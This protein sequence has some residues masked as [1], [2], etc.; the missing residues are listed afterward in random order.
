MHNV[1]NINNLEVS[2]DY[3][4]FTVTS[5]ISPYDVLV[6]LGFNQSDF[7]VCNGRYGYKSSLR[8]NIY[9][10]TVL[11]DGNENM[12]IHV[13]I[14]GSGISP[15]IDVYKNSI[16]KGSTPWGTDAF[17]SPDEGY[18][19]SFLHYL[20]DFVKF[21]RIDL[22]IDDIG[23]N[24]YS[25]NDVFD[26]CR[27]R[28]LVSRFKGYEFTTGE[29][30]ADG[31][32][33]NTLYVGKRSSDCFLRIYDKRLEQKE[34][35]GDDVG[36]DWVRWELELKHNRAQKAVDSLLSGVGL[37]ELSIGILSNYFRVII[38]DDSNTTRCSL[39][40]VWKKFVEGVS[41][42]RLFCKEIEK[43]LDRKK[44]WIKKQVLPSIA[45]V[46][47]SEHGD[48]SFITDYLSDALWQ[49]SKPVLD[50]VFKEN[51]SLMSAYSL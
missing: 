25:V 51:P 17:E 31:V 30:F 6:F 7:S 10:I 40:P 23:C 34:K 46:C 45:A 33:G 2:I 5:F 12:G 38:C 26:I 48:L 28:R 16:L 11:Y 24:Y 8:H 18:V 15:M 19:N 21:S 1:E 37:G 14:S 29:K 42:I 35:I 43:T 50:L 49:N 32:S 36:Y 39:D 20:Y 22:A 4:S 27:T 41:K 9:P 47:A 44:Q 3:L 13:D